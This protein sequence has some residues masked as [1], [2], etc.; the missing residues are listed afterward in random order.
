MEFPSGSNTS[1]AIPSE[2]HCNSP[3]YTGS[4]AL[5]STNAPMMSVPPEIDDRHTSL[6]TAE[7]T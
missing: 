4:T 3:R 1:T 6:F 2:R 5:A 7:Y